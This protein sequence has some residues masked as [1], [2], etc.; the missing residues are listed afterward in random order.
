VRAE[1]DIRVS[2]ASITQLECRARRWINGR[3]SR[4]V[5]V[6]RHGF[7]CLSVELCAVGGRGY[8]AFGASAGNPTS[9]DSRLDSY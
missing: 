5:G 1:A 4:P 2:I 3:C 8:R 7:S 6:D 9:D